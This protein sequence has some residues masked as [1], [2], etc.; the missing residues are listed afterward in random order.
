M[1][2]CIRLLCRIWAL[3]LSKYTQKKIQEEEKEADIQQLEQRLLPEQKLKT[4]YPCLRN[5]PQRETGKW[6][7]LAG[8]KMEPYKL[9]DTLPL[10]GKVSVRH[11]AKRVLTSIVITPK[12]SLT[13]IEYL[14]PSRK[15][16]RIS[17]KEEVLFARVTIGT[18]KQ[19][20]HMADFYIDADAY[21]NKPVKVDRVDFSFL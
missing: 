15:R 16:W 12:E 20:H 6:I 3:F 21:C 18:E 7:I 17:G 8:N 14:C 1:A 19:T 2:F 4:L 10:T 13:L 5:T 9:I 11:T